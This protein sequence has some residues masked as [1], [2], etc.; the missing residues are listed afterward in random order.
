MMNK[1]ETGNKVTIK[2]NLK[3]GRVVGKIKQG[4]NTVY[5][6][7]IEDCATKKIVR[8]FVYTYKQLTIRG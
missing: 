1:I 4:D 7:R 3:S 6:V 2:K 5:F 8:D